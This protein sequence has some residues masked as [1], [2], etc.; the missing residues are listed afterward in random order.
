MTT[1]R[2]LILLL[3]LIASSCAQSV[4]LQEDFDA[5]LP[6][7]WQNLHLAELLDPWGPGLSTQGCEILP[8]GG[9][10]LTNSL[11]ATVQ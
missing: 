5:G 10:R 3:A 9:L 1:I 11:A 7:T 2:I 8:A 4:L 6:A